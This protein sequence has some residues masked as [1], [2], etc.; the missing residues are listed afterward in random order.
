MSGR[1]LGHG[2]P[3]C[4]PRSAVAGH[5]GSSVGSRS[6][7]PEA[8]VITDGLSA[9]EGRPGSSLYR[10]VCIAN[11]LS[12]TTDTA[13]PGDDPD[14]LLSNTRELAQRVRKEQRAT[15]FPLLVF[16]ALTFA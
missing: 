13:Y 9:A 2:S 5:V 15:W 14:R 6:W 4:R 10:L 16:A 3:A 12:M 1:C 8:V 11:L 7:R